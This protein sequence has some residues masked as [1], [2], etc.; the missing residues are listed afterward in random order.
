MLRGVVAATVPERRLLFHGPRDCQSI[1]LTFDDGPD[2]SCTP[3]ILDILQQE[4]VPAT[5]LVVG[6]LAE[7]HPELV[8]RIVAEGHDLGSHSYH[9]SVAIETSAEQLSLET[10]HTTQLLLD[11]VG[12]RPTL[13][14]PPY[15]ALSFAKLWRLWRLGLNVLLWNVDPKDYKCPSRNVMIYWLKR[16]PLRGGD[17][18][19]LHDNRPRAVESLRDVIHAARDQGLS[20]TTPYAWLPFEPQAEAKTSSFSKAL[21]RA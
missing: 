15:G 6:K 8:Q 11:M 16:N 4:K 17:I 10:R 13:C 12:F 5:F 2:P 21:A 14:R 18:V 1:C 7:Q 19:L 9:H 3:R 20:F